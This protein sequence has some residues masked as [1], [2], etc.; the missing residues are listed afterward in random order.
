MPELYHED[1]YKVRSVLLLLECLP[2]I[3]V[4]L[5]DVQ[6][7]HYRYSK[8]KERAVQGADGQLDWSKS[9]VPDALKLYLMFVAVD[10]EWIK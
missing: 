8:M 10:Y 9:V 1:G 3:L 5:E 7:L 2:A 6:V 4:E